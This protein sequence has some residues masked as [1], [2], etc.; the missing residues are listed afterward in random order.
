[1]LGTAADITDRKHAEEELRRSEERYRTLFE[2]MDEGFCIVEM[3]FDADGR[4]VD[5]RFVEINP[6]FENQ[7]R[8]AGRGR[9]DD[10]RTGARP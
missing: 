2:S 5:Y 9:Q 8:A 7:H 1:M 3:M 10:A 4:P 6:A